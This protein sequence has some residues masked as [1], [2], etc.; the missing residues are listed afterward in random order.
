MLNAI[1]VQQLLARYQ[2]L[3]PAVQSRPFWRDAFSR[4]IA[5]LILADVCLSKSAL[6][7]LDRKH[8]VI[9]GPT[10][11][12]KSSLVNALLPEPLAEASALAG[13]TIHPQVFFAQQVGA[14]AA[15]LESLFPHFERVALADLSREHR[16]QI[17]LGAY[18]AKPI[19]LEGEHVCIWDSPDFDSVDAA[20]YHEGVLRTIACADVL[21]LIVSKEKYADQR[22]WDMLTLIDALNT[23][24]LVCIN[25]TLASEAKLVT[26]AFTQRFETTFSRAPNGV[27]AIP[28]VEEG[29]LPIHDLLP[30]LQTAF[31]YTKQ[32]VCDDLLTEF[33]P[34]WLVPVQQEAVV[35]TEWGARLSHEIELFH[36]AYRREYL[37]HPHYYDTFQRALAELL[38]LLEVPG[39]GSKLA[40]AREVITWPLRKLVQNGQRVFKRD[41]QAPKDQDYE[42]ELIT[43]LC[44]HVITRLID[45]NLSEAEDSAAFPL[46]WQRQ[47]A[48]QLGASR[49]QILL[50]VQE[51]V[52]DYQR[53]FENEIQLAADK[54]YAQ[55]QTQPALLNGL[56][57][58][59]VSVDAAA[60]VFAL[61]SGGISLN[62]F[63]LAPAM[64][65]LSS[66]LAE[67]SLGQYLNK[68]KA[69]LKVQQQTQIKQ[70][71]ENHLIAEI[72]QQRENILREQAFNLPASFEEEATA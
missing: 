5:S 24:L 20:G 42:S 67:S 51:A 52:L 61:K 25:K 22:V 34:S 6:T 38:D 60:V 19:L 10:Q 4:S 3:Q 45:L 2:S 66:M 56:R 15:F 57:A 27:F 32:G 40:Q 18:Q 72:Q 68:V 70:L 31:M 39:I 71:I 63:I 11:S 17:G 59:R 41:A 33:A 12:G 14:P 26:D 49:E 65:S 29:V 1:E 7:S 36:K 23:P 69:E 46:M 54:L 37:D 8:L 47:F 9:M 21:V 43:Q 35:N 30:A 50:D 53:D 55:L 28:F 64:L 58:A 13:H 48:R 62:D 16:D 44:D